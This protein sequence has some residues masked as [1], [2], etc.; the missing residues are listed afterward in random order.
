M[1]IVSPSYQYSDSPA[2]SD[3]SLLATM[4]AV[5]VGWRCQTE[6]NLKDSTPE[7]LEY[8]DVCVTG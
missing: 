4:E 7:W 6:E 2:Q 5:E 8:A 1:Q 3:W